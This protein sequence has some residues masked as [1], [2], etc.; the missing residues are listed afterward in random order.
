MIE[1]S[2]P[3]HLF[4]EGEK[5]DEQI[6]EKM[7]RTLQDWKCSTPH[8]RNEENVIIINILKEVRVHLLIGIYGGLVN[9]V[10]VYTDREFVHQKA[11]ELAGEYECEP[12]SDEDYWRDS[13][14]HFYA[15]DAQKENEISV[16]YNLLLNK[17]AD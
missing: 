10:G 16:R 7:R 15:T 11:L 8:T 2:N 4:S 9:E 13:P 5:M 3:P 1:G 6:M 14:D 12:D 17:E